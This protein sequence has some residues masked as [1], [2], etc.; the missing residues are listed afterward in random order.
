MQTTKIT[1]AAFAVVAAT[2]VGSVSG[3]PLIG[4]STTNHLYRFDT[5]NA[6]NATTGVLITGLNFNEQIIGIDRRAANDTLYGLSNQGRLFILNDFSGAA[7]LVGALSADPTD[8][9]NPFTA[10]SGTAFG[11]DFNPVADRLRITTNT[12]Q[13]LRVNP[14]TGLVITDD[15]LNPGNPSIVASAY[16]NNDTDPGTGTTL[17]DFDDVTNTLY[18]QNPPNNGTLVPV[19]SGLGIDINGVSGFEIL[20]VDTAFAA[21]MN[22]VTGKSSIYSIDL[23]AGTASLIGPFGIGGSQ[24]IAPPLLDIAAQPVPEPATS[25][26][27]LGGIVAFVMRRRS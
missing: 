18:I 21:F 5:T 17:Y 12:G 1:S 22:E 7:T 9:T 20:G 8:A 16:T 6:T 14:A 23:T 15:Q 24:A 2:M 27:V 3:A 11:V 4:L 19:G 25:M 13:N 26:L 10:L